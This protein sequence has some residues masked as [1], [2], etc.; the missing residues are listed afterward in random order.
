ML[1]FTLHFPEVKIAYKQIFSMGKKI[2]ITG[3][4]GL[5][6]SHITEKLL[7]QGYA[8]NYLSRNPEKMERIKAYYWDPEAGQFD[9]QALHGVEY[10]INLAGAN[11]GDKR[12][13]P[14]RKRL[15]LESRT[16]STA[17]LRDQLKKGN[18]QVKTIISA[19][20]IGCYGIDNGDSWLDEKSDFGEDFLSN[21]TKAWEDE[22][23]LYGD[24]SIR[25]VILRFGVVFSTSGGA[26]SKILKPVKLGLGAAL[27]N[28]KQWM[29]WIHIDDL[30]GI[31]GFSI[32]EERIN[33][34]YN[35]VSPDPVTNK[36]LTKKAAK[37]MG[38]PLFIP[39]IPAF[40]IR[41]ALGEM[42]TMILGSCRASA[43]KIIEAGYNFKFST[44]DQAL[45][46]LLIRA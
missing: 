2:L 25:V 19:S 35:A 22:A 41:L 6:G 43:N 1:M 5:I 16:K 42:A 9:E 14:E 38:K 31:I 13:L 4:S 12:W 20:A 21:V 15:I 39:D 44:I 34:V 30:A 46:D 26:L 33:G 10:I 37:I 17:F 45:K 40:A 7:A 23:T 36:E 3:G 24:L 28:G 11:I 8:V 32:N 29:S 18:H 27:G